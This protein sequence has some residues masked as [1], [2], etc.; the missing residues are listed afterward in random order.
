MSSITPVEASIGTVVT[1]TGAAFTA[2]GNTVVFDGAFPG[3]HPTGYLNH[4]PSPDGTTLAF[5]LPHGLSA[6]GHTEACIEILLP[7]APGRYRVA[8][9]NAYGMSARVT[10]T[11]LASSTGDVSHQRG[12]SATPGVFAGDV[13]T[14]PA[15]EPWRPGD[16]IREIPE[17]GSD[18][19]RR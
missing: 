14:L 6:C 5:Q 10:F 19:S 18:G 17:G 11:V 12:A 13:R 8:V 7:L 9:L 3:G 1:L 4:L 16:P 15:A 2:R